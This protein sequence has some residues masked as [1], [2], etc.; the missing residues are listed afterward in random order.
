MG[1]MSVSRAEFTRPKGLLGEPVGH[2]ARIERQSPGNLRRVEPVVGLEVFDLAKTSVVDHD[3]TS[4]ICLNTALRSTSSASPAGVGRAAAGL[5][6][7]R[8][9]ARTW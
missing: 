4:Q 2:R 6:T 5:I 1:P 3:N 9:S 8:S 7:S